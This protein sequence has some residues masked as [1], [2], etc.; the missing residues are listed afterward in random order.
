MFVP[1]TF[2]KY[3]RVWPIVGNTFINRIQY[4][5]LQ[6]ICEHPETTAFDIQKLEFPK[7][8]SLHRRRIRMLKRKKSLSK[9]IDPRSVRRYIAKLDS[10]GFIERPQT[11]PKKSDQFVAKPCRLSVAGVYYIILRSRIMPDNIMKAILKNYGDN[12]L[13]HQFVYPYF[14][15]NTLLKLRDVRLIS[16]V[17]LFIYEC[18]RDIEDVLMSR[19]N[20]CAVEQVFFWQSVPGDMNVT[21]RLCHFL[22]KEL[23]MSWIDRAK[24]FRKTNDDSKLIISYGSDLISITLNDTK[25]KA[26]LTTR[27]KK[28]YEFAVETGPKG[29][30]ILEAPTKSAEIFLASTVFFGIKQRIPSLVSGLVSDVDQNSPDFNFLSNDKKFMRTLKQ[31]KVEFDKKYE[32]IV[33]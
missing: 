14:S 29:L 15:R 32:L 21:N 13:F 10:I 17:S 18:C 1:R 26:T 22:K 2:V 20:G 31:A 28:L 3:L 9:S 25:T 16:R 33:K 30:L 5:T 8:R 23:K 24:D 11:S 7:G 19:R 6:Y 4:E 12:M 27:G